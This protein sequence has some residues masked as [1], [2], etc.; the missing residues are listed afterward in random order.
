L[1]ESLPLV[2]AENHA[3]NALGLHLRLSPEDV[4]LE[5]LRLRVAART[6]SFED[7]RAFVAARLQPLS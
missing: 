1:W 2:L 7:L 3:R 4:D 5:N 6:A